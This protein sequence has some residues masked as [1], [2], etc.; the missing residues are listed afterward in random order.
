MERAENVGR[1][2]KHVAILAAVDRPITEVGG[3]EWLVETVREGGGDIGPRLCSRS[4][5]TTTEKAPIRSLETMLTTSEG[6][7]IQVAERV[8]KATAALREMLF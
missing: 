6:V 4:V 8:A 2:Q 1:Q 7:I 3:F 5:A